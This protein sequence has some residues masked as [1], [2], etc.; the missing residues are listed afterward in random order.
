MATY[1]IPDGD[2]DELISK[3]NLA[4]SLGG[5]HIIHLAQDG[6]YTVI[7]KHNDVS[8]PNGFPVIESDITIEGNNAV[9]ER[10]SSEKFRFFRATAPLILKAVTLRGG[11]A[12]N[13]HGG[14]V[15]TSIGFR[16]ENCKFIYNAAQNGG[17][18]Y[19]LA[20]SNTC[21]VKD[22]GFISN[23]AVLL[24][25]AIYT[26]TELGLAIS[27]STFTDNY[28]DQ[29]GAINNHG[30][31]VMADCTL[32]NNTAEGDGGGIRSTQTAVLDAL[33]ALDNCIISNNTGGAGRW[34]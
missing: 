7:E 5:K 13:S 25:G 9:I 19:I 31:L 32:S 29:G 16:A 17:A 4:N 11:D 27:N 30:T 14:A 15:S 18:L 21:E 33:L 22:C 3:I 34:N 24:G 23:D 8:G 2:V 6:I 10:E 20:L 28:A 1:T 12:G 26:A